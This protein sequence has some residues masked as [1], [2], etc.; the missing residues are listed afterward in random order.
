MFICV[1]EN[2]ADKVVDSVIKIF[3]AMTETQKAVSE[4]I[5]FKKKK[6]KQLRKR[7]GSSE[8]SNLSEEEEEDND[9]R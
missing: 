5:T 3:D 2:N 8:E 1:I 4:N 6:T 7:T 9:V